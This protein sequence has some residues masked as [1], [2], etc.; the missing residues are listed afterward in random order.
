M[1]F[2]WTLLLPSHAPAFELIAHRGL[3]QSYARENL[4]N[5]TCTANRIET[6][7]HAFQENT[8]ASMRRAFELGATMVEFDIHP[9]T[10]A[11]AHDDQ[12]VVFHD[13]TLDCRTNA[14]CENGC[15]CENGQCITHQQTLAYMRGLDLGHGYTA[16]GGKSFPFRGKFTGQMPKLEE[17]LDLL[18]RYPERKFLVNWKDHFTRTID[19]FLRIVK[20]YP[21]EVRGRIYFEYY[22][23]DEK[24]FRELGLPEAIYQGGGPAKACFLK[25][26]LLGWTGYFP[27]ECRGTQI[28]VPL[29]E[30]LGR[31]GR[32]FAS[33]RAVDILWGWPHKF[34]E[35]THAH[36]TKIYISQVDSEED[37]QFVK[38]LPIAGIMTNKI[39]VIGPLAPKYFG[40]LTETKKH[41]IR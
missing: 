13:F 10:E 11:P 28:F 32:V 17:A 33:L 21:P 15:R 36:G 38:D 37:L 23:L 2:L 9:T 39:E 19:I 35:R 8:L 31:F 26:F 4:D 29:H 30:S 22:G 24:P 7:T 41:A 3:H 14:T 12:M 34:L 5:E 16:D 18:R 1:L 40:A 20:D 27:R 6:P 25:Y